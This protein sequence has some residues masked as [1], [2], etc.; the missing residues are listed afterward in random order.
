[1]SGLG[2]TAV[3]AKSIRCSHSIFVLVRIGA[4]AV[5]FGF[6]IVLFFRGGRIDGRS[7]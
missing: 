3:L 7:H 2:G 5:I 4:E 1:M 6:S